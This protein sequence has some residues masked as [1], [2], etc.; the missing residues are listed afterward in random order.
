MTN[1][2]FF[3]VQ[4]TLATTAMFLLKPLTTIGGAVSQFTEF[5]GSNG[6]LALLHTASINT[7]AD[8]QVIQY[9]TKLK[10]NHTNAILLDAGQGLEYETGSLPYDVSINRDSSLSAITGNYKILHKGNI[11][12]GV[13]IA[14]T[15]DNDD[16]DKL[17]ALSLYLKKEKKCTV[18]VCLSQLGYRNQNG[19]DDVTLAA[20]STCID[21]IIAGDA[22]NFPSQ[23]VIALNNNN[24]EVIIHS[25]SADSNSCGQIEIDFDAEGRKKHISFSMHTSKN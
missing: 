24:A 6:K 13:I 12:T 10:S 8:A 17:N 18:V 11:K 15:G 21:I 2:R 22:E 20:K 5:N 9:L 1:R 23:P 14:K 4:G 19:P 25:S 16:I 7:Y 3:L